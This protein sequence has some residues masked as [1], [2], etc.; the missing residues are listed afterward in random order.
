[1]VAVKV[2]KSQP[3]P[4]EEQELKLID[5]ANFEAKVPLRKLNHYYKNPRKGN[6]EKVDRMKCWRV[7]T[8]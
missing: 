5:F 7:T 4:E 1:V 6:V 8:P 2:K 3:K